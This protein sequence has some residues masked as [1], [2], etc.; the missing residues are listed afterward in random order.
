MKPKLWNG[1]NAV[2]ESLV[3]ALES[4]GPASSFQ[5]IEAP[6][7]SAQYS[8][9]FTSVTGSSEGALVGLSEHYSADLG[10]S[11]KLA[12]AKKQTLTTKPVIDTF[13][14]RRNNSSLDQAGNPDADNVLFPIGFSSAV[15]SMKWAIKGVTLVDGSTTYELYMTGYVVY[16]NKP[17][18]VNLIWSTM[19]VELLKI[20]NSMSP[21]NT[22]RGTTMTQG[23][24]LPSG[25][26]FGL[27]TVVNFFGADTDT[28][29][30]RAWH[31]YGYD[32]DTKTYSFVQVYSNTYPKAYNKY[33]GFDLSAGNGAAYRIDPT[34]LLVM[35]KEPAT[36]STGATATGNLKLMRSGNNGLS[37]DDSYSGGFDFRSYYNDTTD[38]F[39]HF[40][41]ICPMYG[42]KT[43]PMHLAF[44]W[45][46]VADRFEIFVLGTNGV[47]AV[48]ITHYKTID[49]A[50]MLKN[51]GHA[52]ASAVKRMG[53]GVDDGC[54]P[55]LVGKNV[56]KQIPYFEITDGL[57]FGGVPP[58]MLNHKLVITRFD[59]EADEVI[60]LPWPS[61]YT[62]LVTPYSESCLVVTVYEIHN[63]KPCISLYKSIDIGHTWK[64]VCTVDGNP[65]SAP[66][67]T[68]FRL[69]S[70]P[71]L[72]SLSFDGR[73]AATYPG[74]P[75][76]GDERI[77]PPWEKA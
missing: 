69:P 54:L 60:D 56:I 6:G 32:P 42:A 41:Q 18:A 52:E 3:R 73:S 75:W 15:S 49:K 74:S 62:G 9:G 72:V 50:V 1:P 23:A 37:W 35:V 27:G 8:N 25:F 2:G 48:G 61:G 5:T 59:G 63:E 77:T 29:F 33:N 22:I 10:P 19:L 51:P 58:K 17:V 40:F 65:L 76:V 44:F 34:T 26:S 70:Y 13:F 43:H 53:V 67:T 57:S 16:A 30:Q 45:M 68:D 47:G 31:Y 64:R 11:R 21:A 66:N 7:T 36:T 28:T 12:I 4:Q 14:K 39:I 55:I 24:R 20:N 38:D 46:D 71:N